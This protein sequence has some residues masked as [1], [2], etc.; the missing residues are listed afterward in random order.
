MVTE[1]K[2][3]VGRESLRQIGY[4]GDTIARVFVEGK[5]IARRYRSIDKTTREW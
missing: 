2:P 5:G 3:N 1:L 4:D